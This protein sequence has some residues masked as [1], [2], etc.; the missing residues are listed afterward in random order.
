LTGVPKSVSVSG[1]IIKFPHQFYLFAQHSYTSSI[2][3]DDANTV[4]VKPT[5]VFLMKGGWM[6][7]N[8]PGFKLEF[9]AG[10]D[11]LTNEKYSLG[12]DL[13]AMGGRYYN[14]AM[15]RNYFCKLEMRL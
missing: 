15:P 7:I 5:S 13:N 3:L 11:N 6:L 8:E 12:N 4:S 10:V 14:A 9:S 2:F 1:L